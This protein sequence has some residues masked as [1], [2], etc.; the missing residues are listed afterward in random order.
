LPKRPSRPA[1]SRTAP[2]KPADP[3]AR[4]TARPSAP[5][6]AA[7]P[8]RPGAVRAS[9]PRRGE[10]SRP[11]DATAPASLSPAPVSIVETPP[12]REPS[13]P[14]P[15]PRLEASAPLPSPALLEADAPSSLPA[16][17]PIAAARAAPPADIALALLAMQQEVVLA[18]GQQL[19]EGAVLA[20]ELAACRHPA[21]AFLR[22]AAAVGRLGAIQLAHLARVTRHASGL[23]TP[24]G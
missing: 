12:A 2:R 24:R 20:R 4:D 18:F 15:A 6:A 21:E 9:P 13:D 3:P 7:V 14:A 16:P 23:A 19:E 8:Q 22:H 1:R 10:R 17:R 5:E 11:A